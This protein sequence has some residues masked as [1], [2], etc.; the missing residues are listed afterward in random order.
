MTCKIFSATSTD[1]SANVNSVRRGVAIHLLCMM[2][3]GSSKPSPKKHEKPVA[4]PF[5]PATTLY[6][7]VSKPFPS[8]LLFLDSLQHLNHS[9]TLNY[10]STLRLPLLSK[11]C[12]ETMTNDDESAMWQSATKAF[13]HQFGLYLPQ[14]TAAG[15]V[16]FKSWRKV[17]ADDLWPARKKW[18]NNSD[19]VNTDHSRFKI[20]VAVR[21]RPA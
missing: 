21:F 15:T 18:Q 12:Y 11:Q 20:Q 10:M 6:K 3:G 9:N 19:Q 5:T 4:I 13:A 16:Q 2:G 14:N 8:L 17:F 1:S 7:P